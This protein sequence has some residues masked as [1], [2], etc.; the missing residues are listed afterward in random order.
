MLDGVAVGVEERGVPVPEGLVPFGGVVGQAGVAAGHVEVAVVAR[1][2]DE[3]S[4][5]PEAV[6]GFA[7]LGE[8]HDHGVVEHRAFALGLCLETFDDARD[9]LHV[10]DADFLA[11]RVGGNPAVASVVADD[12]EGDAVALVPGE[13]EDRGSQV[14][15]GVGHHVGQAG[16]EGGDENLGHRF[17]LLGRGGARPAVG[18]DLVELRDVF[19]DGPGH[20]R[21]LQVACLDLFDRVDMV[22]ELELFIALQDARLEG[23]LAFE[24][25]QHRVVGIDGTRVCHGAEQ[26]VV[27]RLRIRVAVVPLVRA[28]GR[29]SR[30]DARPEFR[31]VSR[32]RQFDVAEGRGEKFRQLEVDGR[33]LDAAE[34]VAVRF[35]GAHDR[36]EGGMPVLAHFGGEPLEDAEVL[37]VLRQRIHPRRQLVFVEIHFKGLFLFIQGFFGCRESGQRQ[38]WRRL[39]IGF[40]DE[41]EAL[42]K[43]VGR[44]FRAKCLEA[45]AER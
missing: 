2:D 45:R 9:L 28:R 13:T 7:V 38:G 29:V 26:F 27:R 4:L 40:A 37:L 44:G 20:L 14:V 15:D 16:D 11:D 10:A 33:P 19:R 43:P 34:G 8:I 3:G 36:G 32:Q 6:V 17:V 1:H 25:F 22:A 31:I 39:A 5:Q 30:D 18:V 41:D 42:G 23:F 35:V 12:V 24:E 21:Q